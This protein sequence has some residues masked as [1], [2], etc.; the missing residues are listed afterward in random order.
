MAS[1]GAPYY[2]RC[3]SVRGDYGGE[4]KMMAAALASGKRQL[5]TA[6][7]RRSKG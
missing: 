6:A 7:R 5:K 2:A 4:P 1:K 3:E